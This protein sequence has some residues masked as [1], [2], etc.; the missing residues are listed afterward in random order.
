MSMTTTAC[1]CAR[2][3]HCCEEIPGWFAPTEAV[4]AIK[5]GYASRLSAV[6]ELSSGVVAL[7]PSIVGREGLPSLFASGRCN[8]L[9]KEGLCEIHDSGFK[10]IE[11]R[12]GYGC[13][14]VGPDVYPAIEMMHQ[15][16]RSPEGIAAI[17]LWKDT[18][19]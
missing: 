1:D 7:V 11:C 2:C 14:E 3:K 13:K 9:T 15:M 16:W 4:K 17:K 8:L 12:I 18:L 10:P 19:P 5:A 6:L